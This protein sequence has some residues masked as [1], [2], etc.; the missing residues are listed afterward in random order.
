MGT[1]EI[2]FLALFVA[3]SHGKSAVTQSL[4]GTWT[5]SAF[6]K[7]NYYY[8]FPAIVPGGIYTD[9]MKSGIIKDVFYGFND[10]STKW[11]GNI[12]WTYTL[13]FTGE[14]IEIRHKKCISICFSVE[15]GLMKYDTVN[16][17]FEG[18]DTFASI[19]LNGVIIG[20]TQ[21][22]FVRY[23]YDIK[24][25]LKAQGNNTIK[26][27]FANP[28][29]RGLHLNNKQLEKYRIPWECPP[30]AYHGE[31]HINMLR[32]MQASFS[33]DW[34]PSF[35]SMGLWKPVY[36]QAY[37]VTAFRHVVPRVV[38][39]EQS[40]IVYV[41]VYFE[42]N[43]RS[44]V[45]GKLTL[46]LHCDL[47][48]ILYNISDVNATMNENGEIATYGQ[49]ANIDK[50]WIH[51]WWPNG[52][53]DQPLYEL[54]IIFA[55]GDNY[56]DVII[57]TQRIGFRT[58]ELVQ[59]PLGTGATFY[60]KVNGEPIFAKGSNEIPI[61]VLPELGQDK[62]TIDFLLRSAKDVNMNMLRVW[63]GGVY[64][65]DYFYEVADKLGIMI[66][67]DFMFAC[68]LYPA[69]EEFLNNV[70]AEVNHNTK[71][72][73]YHP[74]IVIYSGNNENEG[75]LVDNW[76]GTRDNFSL[77]KSD[78]VDLYINTVRKEFNRITRNGAIF[79]SSSP[80]NGKLTES[81]GWIG[82]S[83]GNQ[84]WGDVHYYNYVLDPWNPDTYPIPR[85]CSEYGYQSLPFKDTWLT[86]TNNTADL[87]ISGDFMKWR[88]HHPA[89]NAEMAL[90][91]AEN[92]NL[93]DM[94]SDAYTNAFIYLSQ[95]YASQSVKVETEHY[96]R[97][98]S[99]LTD[100]G[101][102]YT[103]GALYWQLNDVWVA[104]TWSSIDYT[105]R[106]KMLHYFAKDFFA[107]II[108]TGYINVARVL[109]VYTVNDQLSP[110]ENVSII[111][112]AY[113][114]DSPDFIP[115]IEDWVTEDLNAS[116][117][118]LVYTKSI[119]EIFS[120]FNLDKSSCF[121]TFVVHKNSSLT[122]YVHI[123]PV[124]YIFPGK[125]KD[126]T[127]S[128]ANVTISS[129]TKSGDN[130][131]D[132]T[133]KSDNIA[134]FVWLNSHEIKGIFSENGFL[135]LENLR[136]VSFKS[137]TNNTVDELRDTLTVTHLK[138]SRWV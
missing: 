19:E 38:E 95:V 91:I 6:T 51:E 136:V 114:Y 22:M 124:N 81:E 55:S 5:T 92:I 59:E 100:N 77:Y 63:G 110:V 66:W 68:S 25:V 2:W 21:N 15:E 28:V 8:E 4:D 26:I 61:N 29:E 58:V 71:R 76:Y 73:Y 123:S 43:Q 74:S 93:P 120:R 54:E 113:K 122:D 69:T 101:K 41:D 20:E 112:K 85:F 46:K 37:D 126:S 103:M 23:V 72:L 62:E 32:K 27:F 16:L 45:Q 115:F 64:E 79:I 102:G 7:T 53:G 105:G 36:L 128:S 132:I 121:F 99:Y 14:L 127:L 3:G 78:Y 138:D 134:L 131:F 1:Q 125:L 129:V 117:S 70:V 116:A 18:V 67:Q 133:V 119:D 83:P 98:R 130:T 97:Y 24:N 12:N 108:V 17:V 13:N 10:N 65:S 60:F 137:S 42:N 11:V 40:W 49:I 87:V 104:P 50:G 107:N 90:L 88:Q 47:T 84:Y 135:Q 57:K 35:P 86:A 109:Q 111:V 106:W 9:L 31:C 48:E 80:T 33:W 52:Y 82:Q 75:V 44:Y 96:R 39:D 94:K 56:Q 89:G 34:G 118:Q 30:D